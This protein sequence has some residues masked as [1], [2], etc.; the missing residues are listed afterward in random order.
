M[1]MA[2]GGGGMFV[3]R[4]AVFVGRGGVRLCLLV[5]ALRMM[6]SCLMV[7]VSGRLM[8]GGGIVMMLACRML[9]RLSHP[10][11]PVIWLVVK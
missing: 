2:V 3:R 5:L 11:S 4:L 6:M 10:I 1:R 9:G 8:S 7:M